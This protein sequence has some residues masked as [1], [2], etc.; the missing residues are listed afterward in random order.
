MA[1]EKSKT[2]SRIYKPSLATGKP[3]KL[4]FPPD[5]RYNGDRPSV[6]TDGLDGPV[7]FHDGSWCGFYGD[8]FD[9][10]I[11]LEKVQFLHRISINWLKI[12][13][14]WIYLPLEMQVEISEDGK[15]WISVYTLEKKGIE[16]VSASAIKDVS[17]TFEEEKGRYVHIFAKNPGQHPLY[18]DGK[19]WL[20]VDEVRVK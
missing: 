5:P 10:Q 11:D 3:L 8:D 20:F 1:R 7:A 6:L 19:C 13:A 15:K 17:I 16:S 14:S 18:P 4:L 9:L 12:E 2:V